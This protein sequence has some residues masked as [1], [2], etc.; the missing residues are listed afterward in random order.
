MVDKDATG[1]TP[2]HYAARAGCLEVLRSKSACL[3]SNFGLQISKKGRFSWNVMPSILL[4]RNIAATA[5]KW[6]LV[7]GRW[8]LSDANQV[9]LLPQCKRTILITKN[10]RVVLESVK[11]PTPYIC[12][13]IFVLCLKHIILFIS[14]NKA[15]EQVTSDSLDTP[16]HIVSRYAMQSYGI[17]FWYFKWWRTLGN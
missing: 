4:E 5:G 17:S 9:S 14:K 2:V 13:L 16:L 1:Y 3:S 8:T 15:A 7:C 10:S 12:L 6:K 11:T